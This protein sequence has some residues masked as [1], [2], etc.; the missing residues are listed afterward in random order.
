M[1]FK[2]GIYLSINHFGGN[3]KTKHYNITINTKQLLNEL[4]RTF[5]NQTSFIF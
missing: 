2:I 1:L 5:E 3:L 4:C